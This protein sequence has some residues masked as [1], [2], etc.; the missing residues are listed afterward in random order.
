MNE[1]FHNSNADGLLVNYTSSPTSD[2]NAT[3]ICLKPFTKTCL[4]CHEELNIIF[5]Q[6]VDIFGLNSI[7]KGSVY[8]SLCK[9]CGQKFYPNFYEKIAIR[10]KFVTPASIYD[11]NFIYFGGKKAYSTELLIH[12][13]SVFLRQYSGFENFQHSYNLSI[14]KYFT[15]LSNR[16]IVNEVSVEINRQY[17]SDIWFIYQ[18]SLFTFFNNDIPEFEIPR[19]LDDSCLYDFFNMNYDQWYHDFV[20][21]W[22]M[23]HITHSCQSKHNN[24]SPGCMKAFIIDGMQKVARP[25][26]TNKNK[27]IITDEF[28]DGIYI[29]CGNTPKAKSGLCEMCRQ[30]YQQQHLP[31]TIIYDNA[32]S[33]FLYFWNRYGESDI[34]RR[35][36]RTPSS[37]F[38]SK[39]L[40]FIDRFHQPNHKRPMCQKERN[41]D[42][43]F[44]NDT[45]EN[46]N[47]EV[48]EQRNSVLKQYQNALSSYSSK[49]ARIAYLLLFHLMN[50][51]RNTCNDQ[52]QYCRKY[53]KA[54]APQ[55]KGV[56]LK[57]ELFSSQNN[58]NNISSQ[59]FRQD[60]VIP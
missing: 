58:I 8:I 60:K 41:I 29:G 26:C 31:H 14:K 38:V 5:N 15:L 13:T 2:T 46:I 50:A 45:T 24:Q 23:H 51:E 19:S 36:R 10:K 27:H 22:A 39:C 52:F 4:N 18:L 6:Y 57:I 32:C 30:N 42:Y 59:F 33:L 7:I 53:A 9:Q 21:H 16:N 12:F 25:I 3:L 55:L 28:P 54:T 43:G 44:D 48:A 47:T 49:K 35:I 20:N 1:L 56:L 40:F 34:Y 17:F 37:N 11:Q